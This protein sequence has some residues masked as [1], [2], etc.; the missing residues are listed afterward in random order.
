MNLTPVFVNIFAIGC[1][2]LSFVKD[3]QKT[4]Q[5]VKI[6]VKM[7][8]NILP[9]LLLIV[10]L[11]GLLLGF[12]PHAIISKFMGDQSG[13]VGIFVSALLGAILYIP[14]IVAFPLA[15]SFLKAG[16][17]ITTVAIFITTLTMIGFVTLPL[18]IKELGK[19]IALLR[20]G[21][22]ILLAILIG[23]IIGAIL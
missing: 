13:I 1:L 15:A 2:V 16:A 20:N 21:V 9:T 8:I 17:S 14:S 18:E 10:V 5:A 4:K 23:V 6:A 11:V 19:K 7:F 3:K 22:S 12:V